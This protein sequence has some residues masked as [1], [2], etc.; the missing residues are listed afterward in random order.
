MSILSFVK[1][2]VVAGIEGWK[3][4]DVSPSEPISQHDA[5]A[6]YEPNFKPSNDDLVRW[7]CAG[8]AYAQ[9]MTGIRPTS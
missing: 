4:A 2:I 6:G 9:S 7:A 1:D 5:G 8:D 3:S